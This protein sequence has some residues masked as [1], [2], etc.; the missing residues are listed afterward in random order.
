[1]ISGCLNVWSGPPLQPSNNVHGNR[2]LPAHQFIDSDIHG[3]SMTLAGQLSALCSCRRSPATGQCT[4]HHQ[5]QAHTARSIRPRSG[6]GA[7]VGQHGDTVSQGEREHRPPTSKP[8]AASGCAMP[9]PYRFMARACEL[10]VERE[11]L[12]ERGSPQPASA[13][14]YCSHVKATVEIPMPVAGHPSIASR[15][16]KHTPLCELVTEPARLPLFEVTP[17]RVAED[18]RQGP[19]GRGAPTHRHASAMRAIPDAVSDGGTR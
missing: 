10:F 17:A 3:T 15:A 9:E 12:G 16:G 5:K 14:R 4:R 18:R 6:H 7:L 19:N 2:Q 13:R 11:Q 1:M 8:C